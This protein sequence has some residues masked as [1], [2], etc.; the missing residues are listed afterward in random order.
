MQ[1]KYSIELEGTCVWIIF[2]D[3]RNK[4]GMSVLTTSIR[5]YTKSS[6]Q[7][8]LSRNKMH[9]YWNGEVTL[10]L[11]VDDMILYT[12]NP[13]EHTQTHAHTHTQFELKTKFSKV[14][15]YKFSIK[16]VTFIFIY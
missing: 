11:L 15:K 7:S 1:V 14:V 8:N 5:H 10:S 9:P 12:E 2:S 4:A 16:K 6:S 13:K 3:V